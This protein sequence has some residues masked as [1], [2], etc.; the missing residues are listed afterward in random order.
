MTSCMLA[1]DVE[2]G[3][4]LPVGCGGDGDARYRRRP[5]RQTRKL[6]LVGN[7][8]GGSASP[9]RY[10][11]ECR[12]LGSQEEQPHQQACAGCLSCL[13]VYQ[14]CVRPGSRR[15]PPVSAF[16][17]ARAAC[18][19]VYGEGELARDSLLEGFLMLGRDAQPRQPQSRS[20]RSSP[21]FAR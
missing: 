13:V 21:P 8:N 1:R 6:G 17:P 5:S 20:T 11:E 10:D 2:R 9:S 4:F 3:V 7:K 14:H 16:L 19:R 18:A 15:N 12:K